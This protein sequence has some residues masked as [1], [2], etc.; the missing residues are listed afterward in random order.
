MKPD[1]LVSKVTDF[2]T[3]VNGNM[4]WAT[5]TQEDFNGE[6]SVSK[7]RELCILEKVNNAWK[8]VCLSNQRI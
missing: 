4:A 3:R 1:G 8:I 5:Y 7:S 2:E 6:T